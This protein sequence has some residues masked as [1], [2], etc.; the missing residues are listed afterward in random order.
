MRLGGELDT[1]HDVGHG[2]GSVGAEHLD[3]VDIGLLGDTVLLTTDGT[4][5]VGTVSVSILISI[6]GRDGLSPVSTALKVDVINVRAGV[7]DVDIDTLTSVSLVNVLVE[8]AE[9]EAL[10][11]RDTC[12]TPRSR[13]LNDGVLV[14]KDLGILL[15]VRNLRRESVSTSTW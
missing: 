12:Q 7:N 8:V 14:G 4:R 9:V 11:V 5:A 1:L 6:A 15:D 13:V 10:L 2:S 3:S